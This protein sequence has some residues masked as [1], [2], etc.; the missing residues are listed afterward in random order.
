MLPERRRTAQDTAQVSLQIAVCN[1]RAG[2]N[3]DALE[4]LADLLALQPQ[5]FAMQTL[6]VPASTSATDLQHWFTELTNV[7][8]AN[9]SE[10]TQPGGNYRRFASRSR[11]PA[12]LQQT[13]VSDSLTVNDVLYAD[14]LNP[15]LQ[16]LRNPLMEFGELQEQQNSIVVPAATPLRVGDLV[17]F[18]TPCGV[19]AVRASDGEI[20]WEVTHPDGR[21]R[22]VLQAVEEQAR[23]IA[24]TR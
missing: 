19:R 24:A 9:A 12:R 23:A 4:S 3:S 10:W 16:S 22:D 14:R 21:I 17:I 15:V 1:S 20:V 5:P 11:G 13:W 8:P 6:P 2:L 18:R 7:P